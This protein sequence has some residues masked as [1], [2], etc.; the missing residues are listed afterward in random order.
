[1]GLSW[2]KVGWWLVGRGPEVVLVSPLSQAE[3]IRRAENAIARQT[4]T[5]KQRGL[6]R[7]LRDQTLARVENGS[8]GY[9]DGD[10]DTERLY[11]WWR[12]PG[13]AETAATRLHITFEPAES[14]AATVLHTQVRSAPAVLAG[15]LV[16]AAIGLIVLGAGV[17]RAIAGLSTG[18]AFSVGGFLL[19]MG[20]VMN[21]GTR[22]WLSPQAP[23]LQQFLGDCA[24]PRS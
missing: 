12:T 9:V 11:L 16:A 10:W 3:I 19:V 23:R 8:A 22:Q 13:G 1:M 2:K 15:A 24:E 4:A 21:L 6:L 5:R 18:A 14:G 17:G 7:D 20:I